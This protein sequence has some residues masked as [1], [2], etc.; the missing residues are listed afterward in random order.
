MDVVILVFLG[1]GT[2]IVPVSPM[3]TPSELNRILSLSKPDSVF[4]L[5]GKIYYYMDVAPDFHVP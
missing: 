5:K 1:I 2:V 4:T 3:L